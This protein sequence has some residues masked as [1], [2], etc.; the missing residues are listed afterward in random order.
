VGVG[1]DLLWAAE[2]V[3]GRWHGGFGVGGAGIGTGAADAAQVQADLARLARIQE[4][5]DQARVA[6]SKKLEALGS[7]GS[8]FGGLVRVADVTRPALV[9]ATPA[10]FV[11]LDADTES[12]PTGE[13]GR[14]EKAD[15]AG[16]RMLDA[17]GGDVSDVTIDPVRELDDPG[18]DRY[19]VVLDRAD[20]SG[21][22]VSF[23][24]LSGEPASFA[25]DRF[26][27]LLADAPTA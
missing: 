9:V 1:D 18:D 26:R 12:N 15:V 7:V 3:L 23:L 16:V 21:T 10:A 19:T 13:L 22:S 17:T 4:A 11:L 8:F 5:S 25:R 20:G 14:I 24:F 27:Q 6:R 2:V